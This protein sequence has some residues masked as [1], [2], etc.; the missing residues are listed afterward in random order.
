MS[1]STVGECPL[2]RHCRPYPAHSPPCIKKLH[3]PR[4]TTTDVRFLLPS[5][6]WAVLRPPSPASEYCTCPQYTPSSPSS[7]TDSS[8]PTHTTASSKQVRLLR[9]LPASFLIFLPRPAYE[10][11]TLKPPP[12]P[13]IICPTA[14][15]GPLPLP[16][17]LSRPEN[18]LP[19]G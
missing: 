19:P 13:S 18:P 3:E 8:A 14:T 17:S 7:P 5:G 16:L 11:S 9:Y 10:V 12:R 1:P 2:L 15:L 4:R 6:F